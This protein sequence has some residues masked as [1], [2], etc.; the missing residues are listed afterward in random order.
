M[1]RDCDRHTVLGVI[2]NVADEE[3]VF[4]QRDGLERWKQQN[5]SLEKE[6]TLFGWNGN[7]AT[8]HNRLGE[9]Q[10]TY[11]AFASQRECENGINSN[12]Y[13]VG[14]IERDGVRF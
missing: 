10:T 13:S 1:C 7:D 4:A 11:A 3:E 8:L 5:Y 9:I 12:D 2:E 6:K 14:T